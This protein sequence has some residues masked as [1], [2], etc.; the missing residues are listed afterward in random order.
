MNTLYFLNP[1]IPSKQIQPGVFFLTCFLYYREG[2]GRFY[3][4]HNRHTLLNNPS[5][6]IGNA[7]KGI[8]KNCRVVKPYVGNNRY[9]RYH[10]IRGVEASAQSNLQ[11][12]HL[13]EFFF[14]IAQGD[15]SKY[16]KKRGRG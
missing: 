5:L 10:D 4:R 13:N 16:L 15:S 1:N 9:V 6:F 12:S 3:G 11:D 7:G 14:K 8:T 2:F